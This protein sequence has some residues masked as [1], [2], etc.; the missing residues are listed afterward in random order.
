MLLTQQTCIP[1]LRTHAQCSNY[2]TQVTKKSKFIMETFFYND[3]FKEK[4]GFNEIWTQDVPH[5]VHTLYHWATWSSP[6]QP[7]NPKLDPKRTSIESWAEEISKFFRFLWSFVCAADNI[8]EVYS[9]RNECV[10]F[11]VITK[12]RTNLETITYVPTRTFIFLFSAYISAYLL[13]KA[14]KSS[15]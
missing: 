13:H 10:I 4:C 2:K 8:N 9:N 14:L 5:T 6:Q 7:F 3:L 15:R 1:F 12:T 11:G